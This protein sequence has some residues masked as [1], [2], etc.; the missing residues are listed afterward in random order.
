MAL[1]W[2]PTEHNFLDA[3]MLA[4]FNALVA[5]RG[6]RRAP[7][8]PAPTRAWTLFLR[9]RRGHGLSC[10]LP[11]L[12]WRCL[13]RPPL[14]GLPS[15]A[16]CGKGGLHAILRSRA[17]SAGLRPCLRP[18]LPTPRSPLCR[19]PHRRRRR[20][21]LCRGRRSL[22]HQ[23]HRRLH[24]APDLVGLA[25]ARRAQ[26]E[27]L[28]GRR[29]PNR[30]VVARAVPPPRRQQQRHL[31]P[32][33]RQTARR[34]VPL[35]GVSG[36]SP[37]G[38]ASAGRLAVAWPARSPRRWLGGLHARYCGEPT[39]LS[40]ASQPEARFG[41]PHDAFGAGGVAAERLRAGFGLWSLRGQGNRRDRPVPQFAGR[42]GPRR[43]RRAGPLLRL[44]L[45]GGA[46]ATARL[47]HGGPLAPAALL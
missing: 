17:A 47:G 20:S 45:H 33:P 1:S 9:R 32:R 26:R 44:V 22:W 27:S 36:G 28:P 12:C 40:P 39:A 37:P 42:A 38:R 4:W 14:S 21:G 2:D 6:E 19:R 29:F 34:R 7:R 46:G 18:F 24:A 15:L 16:V 10:G 3:M 23:P 30:R 13:L 8:T 41:L 5:S 35:P 43:H 25:V 31:L 11:C